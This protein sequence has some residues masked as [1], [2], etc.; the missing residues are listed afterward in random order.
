MPL[1]CMKE[2]LEDA[3]RGGYAVGS[4]SVGNM[5]MILGVIRAA[6]E[7]RSPAILQI[8][9]VRLPYSPLA[10]IGP[11]MVAAARE[12]K[13]PV[14]VHFD[15]GTTLPAITQALDLGFTS[16]MFD[17]S[18][19]PL[20][21]NISGTLAVKELAGRYHAAVEA[22]I[23][24]VGGSEDG[25][26]SAAV[27]SDPKEAQ[28]FY[29]ATQADALAIAI[30]NAHGNYHG[31]PQ[32]HFDVL[33]EIRQLVP[34]PLVLHGGSGISA[35]GFR[36]CIRG[37]VCK[38][39]IATASF[40]ALEREARERYPHSGEPSYFRLSAAMA[41]AVKACVKEHIEIFMSDGKA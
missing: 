12:A 11:M 41:D 3:R 40:S 1:V 9:E 17:G 23:G 20:K 33:D 30:G 22:E 29:Q 7:M 18:K 2:L 25:K 26:A 31:E 38:I 27:C 21:E 19:L 6:E 15:H 36:R 24:Q 14:A 16:V 13:V 32:L 4:F 5:E 39:N 10:L 28:Q 8:A 35:E 37:G 34:A